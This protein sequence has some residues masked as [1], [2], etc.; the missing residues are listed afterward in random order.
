MSNFLTVI[1]V[2]GLYG[3]RTGVL[4]QTVGP[5]PP[6]RCPIM[7]YQVGFFA[8]NGKVGLIQFR[9]LI[10]QSSPLPCCFG[11]AKT[12]SGLFEVTEHLGE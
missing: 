11:W 1:R 10:L 12:S 8:M 9:G 4:E 6:L 2:F 5:S 3:Q 7:S